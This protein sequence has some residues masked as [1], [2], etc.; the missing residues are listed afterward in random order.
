MSQ[1]LSKYVEAR[2][3]EIISRQVQMLQSLIILQELG[4]D[5]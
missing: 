4:H 1:S 3:V 2:V 5:S